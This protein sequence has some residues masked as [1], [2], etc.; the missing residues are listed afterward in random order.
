MLSDLL[1]TLQIHIFEQKIYSIC[2]L[3]PVEMELWT[4]ENY[5]RIRSVRMRA[6]MIIILKLKRIS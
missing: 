5:E 1:K 6:N 4:R 3:N 2:T